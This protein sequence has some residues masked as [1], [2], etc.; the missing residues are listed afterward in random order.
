MTKQIELI[1]AGCNVIFTRP[2]KQWKYQSNKGGPDYETFCSTKCQ[3]AQRKTKVIVDCANCGVPVERK[4]SEL[5]GDNSFCSQSCSAQFNNQHRKETGFTTKGKTRN[6]ICIDCGM[7]TEIS[8]HT[9]HNKAR[10]ENCK[11]IH[12]KKTKNVGTLILVCIDCKKYI[13]N[14]T[15]RKRFCDNCAHIHS[16]AAGI[17]AA[18]SQQRRSKN[19]IFF[20]ELCQEQLSNI[21]TNEQFFV[22]HNGNKWDADIILHDQKVAILWNG[23]WHYK[24]ISKKQ[25][26]AQVQARDIIKLSVIAENNYTPYIIKDMGKYNPTFVKEEFDKF[27]KWLQNTIPLQ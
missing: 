22:D 19:E 17:K 23:V 4:V 18:N 20:A 27:I 9:P 24:Q 1:C 7:E 16:V 15:T 25:S 8:V 14:P 2:H 21:T 13:D 11:P 6:S 10:C 5:R 12:S 26:L 3:Q